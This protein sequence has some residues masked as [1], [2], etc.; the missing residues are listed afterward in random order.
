[1]VLRALL[2]R[3]QAAPRH[4]LGQNFLISASALQEIVAA[5]DLRPTD[6]VVE[7][8][9]G[10]GVLTREL[11]VRVG[12]LVAVEIDPAMRAVLQ[13]VLADLGPSM[14]PQVWDDDVRRIDWR[15]RLGPLDAWKLV[16]NLPYYLSSPFLWDILP[17]RFGRVVV[18]LQQEVGERLTAPAGSAARGAL[19]VFA[20]YYAQVEPV[21]KVPSQSFWPAPKVDSIVLRILPKNVR[22]MSGEMEKVVRCAFAKRRKMLRAA[23][24]DLGLPPEQLAAA[25]DRAQIDP[26]RRAETLDV[27]EFQRLALEISAL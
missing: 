5:A 21:L 25:F 8:G 27:L 9:S 13:E 19:S 15:T 23:L 14:Q 10:P 17:L 26:T 24:R 3:H 12:R 4:H 1:M 2:A 11:A 20:E 7:V 22:P 6:Q 16:A 18:M